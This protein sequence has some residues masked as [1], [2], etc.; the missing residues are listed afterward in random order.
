MNKGSYETKLTDSSTWFEDH[1]LFRLTI[2]A[3]IR[4]KVKDEEKNFSFSPNS[5]SAEGKQQIRRRITRTPVGT[6]TIFSIIVTA[7]DSSVFTVD[8]Y[9][10]VK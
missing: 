10:I 9:E 4:S 3:A 7:V 1:S 6:N 5:T 8:V 2:S